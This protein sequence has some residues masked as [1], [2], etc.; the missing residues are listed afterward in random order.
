[1]YQTLGPAY[2]QWSEQFPRLQANTI[3]AAMQAKARYV[4]L[5]NLYMLDLSQPMTEQTPEA[6]RSIKGRV[7]QQ[8]HQ[9]LMRHHQNGRFAGKRAARQ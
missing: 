2:S 3:Q 7:R 1:V 5:E 9:D 8:M 4:A 6:P